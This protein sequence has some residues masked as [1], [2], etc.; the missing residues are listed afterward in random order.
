MALV[1]LWV[2][3]ASATSVCCVGTFQNL[4]LECTPR[5]LADRN[6]YACSGGSGEYRNE[7]QACLGCY[8]R[9]VGQKR[10][11]YKSIGRN[12]A[13]VESPVNLLR[14]AVPQAVTFE[15]EVSR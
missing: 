7:D 8:R 12:E 5:E 2:W 15:Q 3:V 11:R 1:P 13:R 9:V 14:N 6:G 4:A 10:S